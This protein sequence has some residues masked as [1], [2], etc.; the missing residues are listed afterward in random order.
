MTLD[1]GRLTTTLNGVF[2]EKS[3]DE[4]QLTTTFNGI[5]ILHSQKILLL[6]NYH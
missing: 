1:D 3:T 6:K 5:F 2:I 4:R